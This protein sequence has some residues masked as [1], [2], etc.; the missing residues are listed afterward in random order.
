MTANGTMLRAL[1]HADSQFPSGGFAFSQGLEASCLLEDEIGAFN[2]ADFLVVHIRHRWAEAD[3]VA[4]VRA[5][6][7]GDDLNALAALDREIEASTFGE[8]LRSGSRRNG[9]GL[10]TAH[11]RMGNR[12]AAAFRSMIR[13]G[14]AMGHLALVQG[15]VW[16]S[17]DFDEDTAVLIS[18]YQTIATLVTAAV[19]LG[20]IG[21][22]E[23]QTLIGNT[24]SHV[25]E[26]ALSPVGDD[27]PIRSF[28]P[29]VEIAIARRGSSGQRLFSN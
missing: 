2:L 14:E 12:T 22:I 28:A 25:E 26:A 6:R 5:Y 11:E 8:L 23:A 16:R 13:A 1:Q 10:L 3:R 7:L 18:G 29:L 20:R 15:M 24:L 27:E 9:M 4:L 21:A 17:L 19:R